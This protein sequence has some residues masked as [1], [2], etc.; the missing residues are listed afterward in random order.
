MNHT[1]LKKISLPYFIKENKRKSKKKK[2]INEAETEKHNLLSRR[3]KFV[4][5]CVKSSVYDL[6]TRFYRLTF[7]AFFSVFITSVEKS[8]KVLWNGGIIVN[9]KIRCADR[10]NAGSNTDALG[11]LWW[12]QSPISPIES[13]SHH[14]FIPLL[15]G[16]LCPQQGF[17]NCLSYFFLLIINLFSV[18]GSSWIMKFVLSNLILFCL[19][20]CINCMR[21]FLCVKDVWR[22]IQFA[23]FPYES[24]TYTNNWA[25][26]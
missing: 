20:L 7:R 1:R 14:Y 3:S 23:F 5:L 15:A 8:S 11:S 4:F 24:M 13:S 10:R 6:P 16:C 18:T 12:L 17:V 19:S 25:G 9:F 26:R 2:K 22:D 21:T